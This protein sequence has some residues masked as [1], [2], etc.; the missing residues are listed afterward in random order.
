MENNPITLPRDLREQFF[1]R[2]P[3]RSLLRSKIVCKEWYRLISDPQFAIFHFEKAVPTRRV[4]HSLIGYDIGFKDADASLNDPSTV[5]CLRIPPRPPTS[6]T[7]L[8][9]AEGFYFCTSSVIFFYGIHQLVLTNG[10]MAY[11]HALG[12]I[13]IS[14]ADYQFVLMPLIDAHTGSVKVFSFKG[15]SWFDIPDPNASSV[16]FRDL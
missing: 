2:L 7:R 10:S 13:C 4:H 9:H 5:L 11:H 12:R 16:L 14:M 3:V 6:P 15:N 1:L 8:I